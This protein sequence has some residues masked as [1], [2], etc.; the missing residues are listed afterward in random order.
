MTAK[1]F[2]SIIILRFCKTKVAKKEFYG[3]KKQIKIGNLDTNNIV[4][5]KLS[6]MKKNSKYLIGFL[7]DIIRP[8]VLILTKMSGYVKNFKENNN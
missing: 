8:L 1:V 3:A 6:K 4:I 2:E 7:D 5:S